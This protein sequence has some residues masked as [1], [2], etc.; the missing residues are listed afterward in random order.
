MVAGSG[1]GRSRAA[2]STNKHALSSLP[3]GVLLAEFSEHEVLSVL[4]QFVRYVSVSV[5]IDDD[6][7]IHKPPQFSD[8][9][10]EVVRGEEALHAFAASNLRCGCLGNSC[11]SSTASSRGR[12]PTSITT[13]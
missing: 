7:T 1:V 10:V 13:W 6:G 12:R 8:L 11:Q 3:E 9:C 2:V 4:K 5:T